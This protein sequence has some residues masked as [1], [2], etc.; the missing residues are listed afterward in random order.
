MSRVLLAAEEVEER[1]LPLQHLVRPV[2]P[3]RRLD[4]RD[5]DRLHRHPVL[6][7][8]RVDPSHRRQR[9]TACYRP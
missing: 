4:H 1:Q 5:P 7:I 3:V 9:R 2:R 8:R 6:Q